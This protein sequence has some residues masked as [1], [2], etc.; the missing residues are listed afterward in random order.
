MLQEVIGEIRTEVK[1]LMVKPLM[2][3]KE[4]IRLQIRTVTNPMQM[5]TEVEE[6]R[7]E[8]L[9]IEEFWAPTIELLK[10][11]NLT[12]SV[13]LEVRVRT[14]TTKTRSMEVKIL[15][16]VIILMLKTQIERMAATQMHSMFQ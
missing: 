3:L 13:Y 6:V 1:M 12:I 8:D 10:E 9:G 7:K 14:N 16:K 4:L 5:T 11:V 2:A 15:M